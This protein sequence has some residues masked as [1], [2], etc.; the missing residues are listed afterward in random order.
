MS[1]TTGLFLLSLLPWLGGCGQTPSQEVLPVAPS[2]GVRVSETGLEIFADLTSELGVEF[3]HFNGMSGEFY[4]NENVGAGAGLLDYDNDGDLDLYLVQGRMLGPG[5]VLQDALFPPQSHPLNDR[6]Y[7]N[8]LTETGH[9][10]FT[11]VTAES[12][13]D[14]KGYGMGVAA[15]DIDNDG[16]VDLYVTNFGRNQMFRNN[17]NGTFADITKASATGESRWSTSATFLDFDRD[18]RLDLYVC[19][20][21]DFDFSNHKVCHSETSAVDYCG[22]QAYTPYN[23]TLYRN[24]GGGRF[25]D[26][27]V[28]SRIVREYGSGLGVVASDF[29]LDGWIDIYVAN[30]ALANFLWI[31]QGN[32][33]FQDEA[34]LSGCALNQ[35]GQPEA[36]MGVDLADFDED[37]DED[38]FL[39][40]LIN[41][42]NTLYI[43]QGEGFFRDQTLTAGLG[44]LSRPY[45]GFGTGWI[46]YDNN[47]WLDLLVANGAVKILEEKA[48]AGVA[49]PL[50]E[51][52]LFF[53]NLGDGSFQ[54]WT[55]K[56]GAVFELEEVTRGVALGDLDNDGD[57]DV[58]ISNNN[59]P[60][61]ILVNQVGQENQWLGLRL[62]SGGPEG[63]TR[64][65]YGAKV[66]C[67]LSDG[68]TLWRRLRS[69]SSYLCANDPRILLGLGGGNANAVSV[70][71]VWPGGQ[72]EIWDFSGRPPDRYYTLKRG[73][74]SENP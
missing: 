18:G 14:S 53:R 51:Q 55:A 10:G 66:S 45:T 6:L 44:S 9:L 12:G 7:R 38:L 37:G 60:A 33:E 4:M 15:G 2:T 67:L 20:Y 54:D 70:Q 13:I 50:N 71:V 1:K 39:T 64:D 63:A 36:S 56:A 72:T 49:Y 11:D 29:N 24:M 27:S 34:L 3:V 74:G 31:N 41:E 26:V 28:S 61:R 8:E 68:R 46:D 59:G 16:D 69:A 22:P 35:H 19:N 62:V 52:N 48:R 25:E 65:Q 32:G 47:G 73:T 23:D 5:K 17:G 30:D 58:V 57:L 21:V 42:T 40:H 43:N